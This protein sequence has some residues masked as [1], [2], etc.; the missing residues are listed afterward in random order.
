MEQCELG[1]EVKEHINHEYYLPFVI[2][3]IVMACKNKLEVPIL[4]ILKIILTE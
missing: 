2:L 1:E 4:C 3:L